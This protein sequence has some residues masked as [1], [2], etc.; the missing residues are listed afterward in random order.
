MSDVEPGY[1]AKIVP[2]NPPE[3]GERW[4]DIQRDIAAKIIPGLTHW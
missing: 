4:E 3:L 2:E 1:L